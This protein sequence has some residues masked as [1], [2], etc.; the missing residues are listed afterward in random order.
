MK[1]QRYKLDR[2][3]GLR[4]V[5]YGILSIILIACLV[6]M[7]N[8][9]FMGIALMKYIKLT[10]DHMG[11]GEIVEQLVMTDQGYELSAKTREE[12]KA[13]GTWAMLLDEDG[14]VIWSY[15][16]P[17][18]LADSYSGADIARMSK[19][20]LKDYPVRLR[21][22]DEKI[23]VTGWQKNTLW[24]YTMEFPLSWMEFLKEVWLYFLLINFMWIVGLAFF[25]TRK[26]EKKREHARI[27]WIAGISHDIRTPLSMVMGYADL[28]ENSEDLS[29]KERQ[30]AA[31]IKHQSIVMRELI[32]DL[33]LT[34]QLEY[35]MQALRK[36]EVCLAAVLREVAVSFLNDAKEGQLEIQ[37]EI[38]QNAENAMIKA[39]RRL[40]I[41]AFSNLLH[42]S[43]QHGGQTD[44]A[45]IQIHMRRDKGRCV[46]RFE[47]NGM[48][49]SEAILRQLSGK[50]QKQ[51]AQNIRGLGIVQKII[52]A[53]G[54]KISFG[55]RQ[56]GGSFCEMKL[57]SIITFSGNPSEYSRKS[58]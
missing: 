12:M 36:E 29:D 44:A 58:D 45:A 5:L 31:I 26:W 39:D 34:S 15:D 8:I 51:T 54:G 18:E 10:P 7:I 19:W 32:G 25:F 21:V 37:L 57:R 30:Q 56:G 42:N 14:Q 47:D 28:L 11:A 17:S 16:K 40:L 46:I 38:D 52:L 53:H 49:Y 35:S 13:S 48:G 41:R 33:N 50:K 43:I 20:Y 6:I 1:K 4:S 27:E 2:K 24:K 23:L 55:N 9:V 22:W 3:K